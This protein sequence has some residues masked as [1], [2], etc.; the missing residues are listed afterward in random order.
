MQRQMRGKKKNVTSL[1]SFSGGASAEN[2]LLRSRHTQSSGEKGRGS[3]KWEKKKD[4]L[5]CMCGLRRKRKI[6]SATQGEASQN[7]L[8]FL[9]KKSGS[10]GTSCGEIKTMGKAGEER[11][12]NTSESG[13]FVHS[14]RI[15][16][17]RGKWGE[18]IP[19]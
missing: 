8:N 16:I 19:A 12:E 6:T 9:E 3:G 2:T 14:E 17:F 18:G 15:R 11:E 1:C 7:C 13:V 10:K 5:D 4:I